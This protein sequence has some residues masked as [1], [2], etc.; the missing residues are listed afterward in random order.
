MNKSIHQWVF[1]CKYSILPKT[2]SFLQ[3]HR[4]A[5]NCYQKL[6]ALTLT[7]TMIHW[8][9]SFTIPGRTTFLK[10][11]NLIDV[12]KLSFFSV[13]PVWTNIVYTVQKKRNKYEYPRQSQ[14]K[15]TF[16]TKVFKYLYSREMTTCC[17]FP[18]NSSE[19]N[20]YTYLQWLPRETVLDPESWHWNSFLQKENKL[21]HLSLKTNKILFTWYN[22]PDG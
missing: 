16:W 4:K 9:S 13:V 17:L 5:F 14:K 18:M 22:F 2:C 12:L 1:P 3:F 21:Q 8:L 20:I 6:Q 19:S 10:R 15:E 11:M 7:N